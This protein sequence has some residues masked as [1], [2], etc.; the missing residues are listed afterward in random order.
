MQ[1]LTV[2]RCR[3]A[4]ALSDLSRPTPH[5]DARHGSLLGRS[6]QRL[7]AKWSAGMGSIAG[8]SATAEVDVEGDLEAPG[9][10]ALEEPLLSPEDRSPVHL[11]SAKSAPQLETISEVRIQTSAFIAQLAS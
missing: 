7:S 10:S 4:A 2:C 1:P 5:P 8:G 11:A 6:R 3:R 9:P